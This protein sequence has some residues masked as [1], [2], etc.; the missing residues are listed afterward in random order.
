MPS[1]KALTNVNVGAGK[2]HSNVATAA[3]D[4]QTSSGTEALLSAAVTA[5][6]QEVAVPSS[7]DLALSSGVTSF[8]LSGSTYGPIWLGESGETAADLFDIVDVTTEERISDNFDLVISVSS[9]T[10]GAVGSGTFTGA[11]LTINLSGQIPASATYRVR[12]SKRAT[13]GTFATDA[14][15]AGRTF[16]P[17]SPFY[18]NNIF[19][20]KWKTS[21]QG[22]W[23]DAPVTTLWD[24]A[25]AGL[26]ERYN[27]DALSP[28]SAVTGPGEGAL[29][30]RT[31]QAVTVEALA[32]AHNYS[33][34]QPDPYWAQ[35]TVT[36][37]PDSVSTTLP[38][39]YD[40]GTGFVGVLQQRLTADVSH[41]MNADAATLASRLDVV[42]RDQAAALIGGAN[43]RTRITPGNTT[44]TA[45]NPQGLATVDAR[46]EILLGFGDYFWETA[47]GNELSEVA[48]G[49]DMIEVTFPGG[50]KQVY[51]ITKLFGGPH[52]VS[53]LGSDQQRALVRTLAGDSPEFPPDVATYGVSFR[54]IKTA[55]WQGVGTAAYKEKV[56]SQTDPVL[57]NYGYTAVT[58]PITDDP[59][60][61]GSDEVDPGAPQFAARGVTKDHVGGG[62]AEAPLAL[63]W[64]GHDP[65]NHVA[66]MRGRLRG[67]GAV[68]CTLAHR[69]VVSL[70]YSTPSTT[71]TYTWHPAFDGSILMVK[72]SHASSF[73]D[74]T[75]EFNA[76]YLNN[77]LKEGDEITI[78]TMDRSTSGRQLIKHWPASFK[79]SGAEDT[80][81]GNFPPADLIT[82]YHGIYADIDGGVWLMTTTHYMDGG[83]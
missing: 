49:R 31:G 64:G 63:E 59:S 25:Y 28:L 80:T 18:E 56:D 73:V 35:Y 21:S 10:G 29:I 77:V 52:T 24:A 26:N 66:T 15:A 74:F 34:P 11:T 61:T 79:F 82:K 54:F 22:T 60:G 12:F 45:L 7:V 33:S 14:I 16:A 62:S 81:S 2:L 30:S 70:E 40:G 48:L 55:R 78:I 36:A 75:L 71:D 38:A 19:S 41:R 44:S 8:S 4:Y 20:M 67:D 83:A 13:I 50:E 37:G 51:V 17:K 6:N 43:V 58:P 76:D 1:S 57:L 23:V 69:K 3:A 68:E 27:R 72:T 42:E 65:E 5:L 46:R 9:I 53:G 47:S 32:V 39:N